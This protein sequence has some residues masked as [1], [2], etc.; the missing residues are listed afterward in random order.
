MKIGISCKES[1]QV[2]LLDSLVV[3]L[4]ISCGGGS[5]IESKFRISTHSQVKLRDRCV[6]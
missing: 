2:V 6:V 5:G 1:Q 3:V 4:Y